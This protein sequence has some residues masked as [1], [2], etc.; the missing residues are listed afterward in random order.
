MEYLLVSTIDRDKFLAAVRDL[1]AKGYEPC[2]GVSMSISQH[3][4]MWFAQAMIRR[5]ADAES[6]KE[7][8]CE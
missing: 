7:P 1:I 6:S 8:P 5:T 4:D 3:N 2:G